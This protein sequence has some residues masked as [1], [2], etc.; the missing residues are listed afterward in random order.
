MTF[1]GID[2]GLDGAVCILN[3]P[4]APTPRFF[5]TPYLTVTKGKGTKRKYLPAAMAAILEPLRGFP[6]VLVGVELVGAM[7]GQGVTSMFSIGFGCGLWHGIIAGLKLPHEQI[8]PQRWKKLFGLG[9]DKNASIVRALQIYPA[10]ASQFSR[11][12]DHG[13]AEALLIAEYLRRTHTVEPPPAT[14]TPVGAGRAA[15]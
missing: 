11:K 10:C 12:K 7:P 4:T 6:D 2:P 1:V 3:G 8:T 9:A 13:R 14:E 15:A 5:D